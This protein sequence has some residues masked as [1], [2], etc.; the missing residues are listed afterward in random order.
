[1]RARIQDWF[2][3]HF[4][5]Q[6]AVPRTTARAKRREPS[7]LVWF[8]GEFVRTTGIAL[9]GALV[10]LVVLIKVLTP[11]RGQPPVALMFLAALLGSLSG[12]Y[13]VFLL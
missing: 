5:T 6:Y 13:F 12:M 7:R 2:A 3:Y 1:M 4:G 8:I 9:V 11:K 10:F